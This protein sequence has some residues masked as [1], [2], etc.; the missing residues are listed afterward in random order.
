MK[1]VAKP[2]IRSWASDLLV[3]RVRYEITHESTAL[4]KGEM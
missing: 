4:S 1:K 2:M 3:I